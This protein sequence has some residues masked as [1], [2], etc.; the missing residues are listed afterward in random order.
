MLQTDL[1]LRY[2]ALDD[3]I[4]LNGNS[5]NHDTE[6]TTQSILKYGFRDPIEIDSCFETPT[7][8]AGHDRRNALLAIRSQG[9]AAP[10]GIKLDGRG[11]WIIPCIFYQSDSQ[12][13]AVA[14]SIDN[15]YSTIKGAKLPL[16]DE[17]K[18]FDPDELLEQ[19]KYLTEE[20]EDLVSGLDL[21][22]M[23]ELLE[24]SLKEQGLENIE[25][26]YSNEQITEKW[27]ILVTCDGEVEQNI[28][29]KKF[30][31]EGVQCRALI[32]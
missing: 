14:Y 22:D 24:E 10:K 20:N 8:V 3:L 25:E 31:E 19:I 21:D 13:Q 23:L 9:D 1:A 29:L 27:Q 18:L 30:I 16:V 12:S 4:P 15:N 7:I 5:K 6:N 28:L 11:N 32:S 17:L 26:D 2:V